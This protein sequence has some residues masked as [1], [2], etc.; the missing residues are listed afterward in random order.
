MNKTIIYLNDNKVIEV[1]RLIEFELNDTVSVC[2]VKAC[3]I[4]RDDSYV[5]GNF[6]TSVYFKPMAE[7]DKE[8]WDIKGCLEPLFK[9]KEIV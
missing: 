6:T 4:S 3:T 9:V 8:K 1:D 2:D 5:D 7:L